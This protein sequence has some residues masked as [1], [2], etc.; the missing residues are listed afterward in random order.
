MSPFSESLGMPRAPV[1]PFRESLGIARDAQARTGFSAEDVNPADHLLQ[2]HP[3]DDEDPL[4][5][6]KKK[7]VPWGSQNG[8]HREPRY[9]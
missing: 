3:A 4:P 7:K 8:N 1:D 6:R 9:L 5:G 2:C